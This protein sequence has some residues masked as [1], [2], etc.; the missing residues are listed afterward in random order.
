MKRV[1][2]VCGG[3]GSS[4][5]AKLF[6][7]DAS[8]RGIYEP[9]YVT[10]VG[11]NYWYHGLY[12]CPDV[13]IITH[14]LAGEL[15]TS[16]GWGIISDSYNSRGFLEKFAS[17]QEWFSLGDGDSALSERRT[18][19]MRKGWTLSTITKRLAESLGVRYSI[20][21]S[22]DDPVT[23]F[24]RT[25]V[26]I[27]HLQE[28]WVKRKAIPRALDVFYDGID[29]A[30]PNKALPE[31]LSEFA[32]IC[33]ANP[34]TSVLPTIRLRGV[35]NILRRSKV[36]A[37]SPFVGKNPFSGPASKLMA[38]LG[39]ET[40]S[41]GVASIYA[42]F[43]KM[44]VVDRDEDPGVKNRIRDLGVECIAMDTRANYSS[45]SR[46]ARDVMNLL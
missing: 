13:D 34:I 15:D 16:K 10:N 23:T 24:I 17:M 3:S 46:I 26:G 43:L 42:S 27:M 38:A 21:P 7:H 5:F 44:F 8:Q 6:A 33:P 4:K 39:L 45:D 9:S 11:D 20:H 37:I 22:T 28:Y 30:S 41:I 14:V 31:V 40:S 18:E 25:T 36:V 2:I 29:R 1:G 32:V 12:V 19:L 35:K